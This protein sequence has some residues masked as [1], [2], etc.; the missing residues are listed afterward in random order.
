LFF[1]KK[2]FF[3]IL[4]SHVGIEWSSPTFLTKAQSMKQV[5]TL[6]FLFLIIFSTNLRAAN[7]NF[8]FGGRQAGMG[9]A[10]VAVYDFWA[11]SHNQAGL[12]RQQ[13]AAGGFYFENRYLTKEMGLGAAGFALPAAGGVFGLSVTYFGYS[14]YHESKF[15]L[16]YA[17]SFGERLSAGVQL[18]YLYTF[19]GEGYGRAGNLA[20]EMGV[21]YELLPGLQIGAHLFNPTRAR[22]AEFNDERIPTIMRLGFA[23]NFSD[24]VLLS[25]ETEKDLER[26]AVFRLGLEYG[27]T[28]N[29]YLRG[30]LGTNPTTNAFGFGMVL[31]N[32]RIDLATS[33]H[34]VLGYSPQASLIYEL[35]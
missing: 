32:L 8:P 5:F 27:I 4:Y 6:V 9:N 20:A 11:L 35:K 22:I 26:D 2:Q 14:Q 7:D 12:A 25:F 31:G 10:A 34:H 17:R 1:F 18:N 13:Y 30:G 19:I 16:S 21:I 28:E 24:R 33:F 23:Y 15:G 29:I 3:F